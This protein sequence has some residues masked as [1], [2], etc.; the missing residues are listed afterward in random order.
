MAAAPAPGMA[1]PADT[2]TRPLAPPVG[3]AQVCLD[4]TKKIQALRALVSPVLLPSYGSFLVL[5][6]R[7]QGV[8]RK[9]KVC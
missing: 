3:S 2:G 4:G 1:G 5:G 9:I 6:R 8:R 7:A